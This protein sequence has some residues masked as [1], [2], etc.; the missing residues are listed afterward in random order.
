M[1]K[2][3][4]I[5]LSIC[6]LAIVGAVSF[7]SLLGKSDRTLINILSITGTLASLVGLAITYIQVKE[8]KSISEANKEVI[9]ETKESIN[10]VLLLA[11]SVHVSHLIEEI[12]RYLREDKL[13]LALVRMKDLKKY[14]ISFKLTERFKK[15]ISMPKIN[16]KLISL[17]THINNISDVV[18]KTVS[19]IQI[20]TQAINQDLE[21]LLEL[22]IEFEQKTKHEK[23]KQ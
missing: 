4:K 7:I 19:D 12:Q 15:N 17:T 3:N 5:S 13:D 1:S 22:I 9:T 11:D 21:L 18:S 2:L 8:I 16:S 10:F 6:I 20:D 23:L 14:L